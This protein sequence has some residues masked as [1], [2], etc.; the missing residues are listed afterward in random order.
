MDKNKTILDKDNLIL[1]L[2]RKLEKFENSSEVMNF[3]VNSQRLKNS[4]DEMY[5]VGYRQVPPPF[6]NNYTTTPS[7]DPE[8]VNF[9]PVAP[10]TVDP[11]SEE[12]SES[13]TDS[14]SEQMRSCDARTKEVNLDNLEDLINS[15]ILQA[16]NQVQNAQQNS[17]PNKK[18]KKN[19]KNIRKTNFVKG[20]TFKNELEK[21]ENGSNVDFVKAILSKDQVYQMR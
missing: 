21:I 1:D 20:K 13:E 9:V 12:E 2:Q 16:L 7:I 6:N 19:A 11:V 8:I 4:E 14:D 15:K 18:G 17:K 3:C 10:L 5:G